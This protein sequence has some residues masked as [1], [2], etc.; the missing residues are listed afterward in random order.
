LLAQVRHDGLRLEAV[1]VAAPLIAA[2]EGLGVEVVRT[3]DLA[4]L[5]DQ[6]AQ[7]LAGTIESLGEQSRIRRLQWVCFYTHC[8]FY[9]FKVAGNITPKNSLAILVDFGSQSAKAPIRLD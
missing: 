9:S 5:V 1:G 8:H 6:Y 2:F 7:R 4:G 3:F